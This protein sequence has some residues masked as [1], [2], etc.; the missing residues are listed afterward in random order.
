MRTEKDGITPK[1]VQKPEYY[2][3]M[4]Q[5]L[6]FRISAVR[7]ALEEKPGKTK[8]KELEEELTDLQA[9][10][11]ELISDLEYASEHPDEIVSGATLYNEC[12]G[13][14]Y[15]KGIY[16]DDNDDIRYQEMPEEYA[17]IGDPELHIDLMPKLAELPAGE[18]KMIIG[19][20]LTSE[21]TPAK[22]R[23]DLNFELERIGKN[24]DDT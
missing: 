23:D 13:Y 17:V 18:Q 22:Y 1:A 3:T 10:L 14:C 4:M 6:N 12:I 21:D 8:K 24:N 11:D 2:R 5:S 9:Q 20:L 19:Y 16:V 15:G 7:A